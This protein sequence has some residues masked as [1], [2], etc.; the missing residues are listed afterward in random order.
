MTSEAKNGRSCR[1]WIRTAVA[2]STPHHH[3]VLLTGDHVQVGAHVKHGEKERRTHHHRRIRTPTQRELHAEQ[4]Q[5]EG[6]VDCPEACEAGQVVDPKP[7]DRA[8]QGPAVD[9]QVAG[10]APGAGTVQSPA[11]LFRI[12]A[13]CP[14]PGTRGLRV[15][16][17][18]RAFRPPTPPGLPPPRGPVSSRFFL[19]RSSS[20]RGRLRGVDLAHVVLLHRRRV[21][22]PAGI[23]CPSCTRISSSFGARGLS[24]FSHKGVERDTFAYMFRWTV[25]RGSCNVW[26]RHRSR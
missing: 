26:P 18:P 25:H 4:R 2:T 12:R 20:F 22:G 24:T 8:E 3:V 17:W 1:T 14:R 19:P 11:P 5:K 9:Q 16:A 23:P 7:E 15:P 13:Q 10:L 21:P 6:E